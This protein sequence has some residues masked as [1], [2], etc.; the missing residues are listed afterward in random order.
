MDPYQWDSMF[1]EE[2]EVG[3]VTE[4]KS[5]EGGAANELDTTIPV[6]RGLPFHNEL[7]RWLTGDHIGLQ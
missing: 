2:D 6:V 5:T 1:D 7:W 3:E 4:G